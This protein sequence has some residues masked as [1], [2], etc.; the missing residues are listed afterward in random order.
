M[1]GKLGLKRV[2]GHRASLVRDLREKKILRWHLNHMQMSKHV[3]RPELYKILIF[4]KFAIF[5]GIMFDLNFLTTHM[6]SVV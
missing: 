2:T 4:L 6:F 5:N 3:V 1:K